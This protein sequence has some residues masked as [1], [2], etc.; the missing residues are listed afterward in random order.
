[1]SASYFPPT[2]R[3]GEGSRTVVIR[4]EISDGAFAGT[5]RQ[6]PTV[7]LRRSV[8]IVNRPT[9]SIRVLSVN[10]PTPSGTPDNDVVRG[11]P[12]SSGA[13]AGKDIYL[14]FVVDQRPGAWTLQNSGVSWTTPWGNGNGKMFT[15]GRI[16]TSEAHRRFT[17]SAS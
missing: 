10:V 15:T 12:I 17:F 8:V 6:D 11:S 1:L 7:I 9:I 3:Q 2:L 4:C 14:R 16:P 13:A 5:N